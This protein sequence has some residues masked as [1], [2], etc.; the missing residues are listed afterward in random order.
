MNRHHTSTCSYELSIPASKS[1]TLSASSK[2]RN[3]ILI[4][5]RRSKHLRLMIVCN[6]WSSCVGKGG[7]VMQSFTLMFVHFELFL[8]DPL[9]S[10]QRRRRHLTDLKTIWGMTYRTVKRARLTINTCHTI[11]VLQDKVKGSLF[12]QI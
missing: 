5:P 1:V 3:V 11:R 7:N 12:I 10:E 6:S 9:P 8:S 4:R 2:F